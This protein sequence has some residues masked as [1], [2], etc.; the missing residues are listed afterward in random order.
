MIDTF[1]G[2]I[3]D[4]STWTENSVK[5]K[6]TQSCLDFCDPMDCL[7]HS[8][9]QNAGVGSLSLFQGVF[10]P[11]DRTQVSHIAGRFFTSCA[12][13][14]APENAQ[15]VVKKKKKTCSMKSF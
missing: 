5:V 15:E 2:W 7:W 12:T 6:V 9:G 4:F 1:T 10:Q 11:K 13:R 8:P 3:E 14:E